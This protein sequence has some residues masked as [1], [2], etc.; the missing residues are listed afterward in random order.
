MY[1]DTNSVPWK[2]LLGALIGVIPGVFIWAV[3]GSFGVT[4]AL[5]GALIVIGAV[6]LYGLFGGDLDNKYGLIGILII[7]ALGVY[8][9]VH[10]AW[11]AR[12]SYALTKAGAD[13]SL[14]QCAFNLFELLDLAELKGKYFFAVLKGYL[15]AFAGGF[16]YLAKFG[17]L[18]KR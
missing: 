16:G 17:D 6:F 1:N 18:L 8:F 14:G 4:W 5:I 3:L 13:Y 15:F 2:G 9:G 12:L 10:L 7:C 11:S